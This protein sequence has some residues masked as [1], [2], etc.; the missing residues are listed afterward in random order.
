MNLQNDS[1]RTRQ[2]RNKMAST[3]SLWGVEQLTEMY[4]VQVMIASWSRKQ[5]DLHVFDVPKLLLVRNSSATI[6]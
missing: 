6:F 3:A 2:L 1:G 4:H 5:I